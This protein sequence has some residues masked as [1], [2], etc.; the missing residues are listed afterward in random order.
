[1]V[2]SQTG[3]IIL[4]LSVFEKKE[5][6]LSRGVMREIFKHDKKSKNERNH[7]FYFRI[8]KK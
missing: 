3:I 5:V 8:E 2:S 4:T 6:G 1:M 7:S